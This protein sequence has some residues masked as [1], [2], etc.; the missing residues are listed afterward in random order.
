MESHIQPK[1]TPNWS[2]QSE[3]K[4][5]LAPLLFRETW[6]EMFIVF[7]RLLKNSK[8]K[9][10][11]ICLMKSFKKPLTFHFLKK[12]IWVYI[13]NKGQYQNENAEKVSNEIEDLENLSQI[14]QSIFNNTNKKQLTQLIAM[15]QQLKIDLIKKALGTLK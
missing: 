11:K 1:T 15:F 10:E 5:F 13:Q 2:H 12:V 9:S 4:F 6:N 3:V 8:M 14:S 7:W